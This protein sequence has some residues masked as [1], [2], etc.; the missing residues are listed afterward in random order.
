MK[1]VITGLLFF[2]VVN[3]N[4]QIGSTF[5]EIVRKEGVNY[6]KEVPKKLKG[7]ILN[8]KYRNIKTYIEGREV[9]VNKTYSFIKFN[10]D[11]YFC[12]LYFYEFPLDS[13]NYFINLMKSNNYVKIGKFKWKDYKDNI[14]YKIRK[15][16]K[17]VVFMVYYDAYDE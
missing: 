12:N 10:D 9:S 16:N 17:M 14:I 15:L 11:R 8:I 1:H 7:I 6:T 13:I 5:E 4:A 2:I 3:V